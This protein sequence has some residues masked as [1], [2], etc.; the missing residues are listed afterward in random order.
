MISRFVK[1]LGAAYPQTSCAS[2]STA[3]LVLDSLPHREPIKLPQSRSFTKSSIERQF[4]NAVQ[5]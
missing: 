1:Y 3:Q 4:C 5:Y 2:K